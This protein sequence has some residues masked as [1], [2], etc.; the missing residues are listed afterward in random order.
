VGELRAEAHEA[1]AVA[2]LRR[3]GALREVPHARGDVQRVAGARLQRRI[4]REIG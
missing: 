2:A 3:E 1:T 4:V